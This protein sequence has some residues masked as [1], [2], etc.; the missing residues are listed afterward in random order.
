MGTSLIN[1]LLGACHHRRQS[2]PFTLDNRTYKVCLSCGKQFGYSLEN[3]APLRST[4]T[5]G[6]QDA[7]D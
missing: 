6:V 1:F 5:T 2:R 3:M 7:K 4:R